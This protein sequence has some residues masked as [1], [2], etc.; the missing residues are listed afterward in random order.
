M[1]KICQSARDITGKGTKRFNRSTVQISAH[2]Q[3]FT[4]D[5]A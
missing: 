5:K 1:Q 4:F 2:R 3:R